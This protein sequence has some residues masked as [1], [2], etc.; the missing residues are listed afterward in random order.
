MTFDSLFFVVAAL[1]V[2]VGAFATVLAKNPIRGAMGLLLSL[3]GVAS[4][5]LLLHA[6]FLAAI[7]IIVYAGAVV[8]L[9]V[10]VI[11][12]LG[13]DS[14]DRGGPP[15]ATL[16]RWLGALAMTGAALGTLWLVLTAQTKALVPFPEA[17]PDHGSVAAVGSQIFE[18]ALL[19]FELATAL[20]IVAVV[21][22]IAVARNLRQ[23]KPPSTDTH[24][25]K[26]L[27]GGPIQAAKDG[28]LTVKESEP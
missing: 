1:L 25:T 28:S 24:P 8:V 27:F 6:E 5:Y 15:K 22:A 7:Q 11:L 19:P 9:F 2:L 17:A 23:P 10:F 3:V 16:S 13:S 12:L 4:L 20:L 26:R 21:G 14:V 18:H